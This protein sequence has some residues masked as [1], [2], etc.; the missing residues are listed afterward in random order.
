M[1]QD[2]LS[3]GIGE[4][5]LA[6]SKRQNTGLRRRSVVLMIA[7]SIVTF[8]LYPAFWFLR[9]RAALNELDSPRKLQAWPF[10]VFLAFVVLRIVAT[11]AAG[12][13][14]RGEVSPIET[15][16]GFG[17]LAVGILMIVQ[18]FYTKTILE[19]HLSGSGDSGFGADTS[20]S[21]SGVFTVFFSIFYLQHVIN[22]RLVA[23]K[24]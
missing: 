24:R 7:L 11:A 3:V 15:L 1:S 14:P 21:L 5:S 22:T 19:D 8:G 13:V 18:C 23:A 20:V 12:P 9:R 10:F 2:S 16:F 6:F 17:Q 4:A